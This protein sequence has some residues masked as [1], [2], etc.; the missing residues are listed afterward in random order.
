M[1]WTPAPLSSRDDA[2]FKALANGLLR[3]FATD[4][5]EAAFAR[6][7]LPPFPL[8]IA[9][10]HHVHALE[11]IAVLVAGEG[12]N[13]LRAQNFLAVGRDQVLQPGHEL[14]RIERLVAAQRQRLHFLVVIVLQAMAVIVVIMVIM[15]MMMVI[16]VVIMI[17]GFEEIRLDVEDAV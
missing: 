12:Q 17:V 10:Q 9:L 7:A 1:Q 13:A 4:K 11:H 6:L 14:R 5:D 8:V 2:A 3:Q 16:V 15:A